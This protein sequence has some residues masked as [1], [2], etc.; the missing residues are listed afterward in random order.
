ME[1]VLP[2]PRRDRGE[3]G[4][5][6]DGSH[7]EG[8]A[9]PESA[10]SRLTA[11]K[12]GIITGG[13]WVAVERRMNRVAK[14]E[15]AGNGVSQRVLVG[16]YPGILMKCGQCTSRSLDAMSDARMGRA[17]T[18]ILGLLCACTPSACALQSTTG[19]WRRRTHAPRSWL[20]PRTDWAQAIRTS[21][22]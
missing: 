21:R 17:S 18:H 15:C 13:V 1:C 7:A 14:A 12:D 22:E 4:E 11:N 20:L 9:F 2:A 8:K 19:I 16:H 6:Q 5:T 10:T 3:T